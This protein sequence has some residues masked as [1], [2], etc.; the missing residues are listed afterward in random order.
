MLKETLWMLF[1][2]AVLLGVCALAF[3]GLVALVRW[4]M[5]RE[6]RGR[7]LPRGTARGRVSQAEL[8][9]AHRKDREQRE[10]LEGLERARAH[11]ARETLAN[12]QSRP[13]TEGRA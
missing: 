7:A 2:L 9:A 3:V 4:A 5:P 1:E 13:C 10:A 12:L 11:A 6:P 8:E